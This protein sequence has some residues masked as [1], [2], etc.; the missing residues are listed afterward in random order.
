MNAW[1]LCLHTF[2]PSAWVGDVLQDSSASG[3][4]IQLHT[5]QSKVAVLRLTTDCET[6]MCVYLFHRA[7]GFSFLTFLRCHSS[8]HPCSINEKSFASLQHQSIHVIDTRCG[9][10]VLVAWWNSLQSDLLEY[11]FVSDTSLVA[12]NRWMTLTPCSVTCWGRWTSSLRWAKAVVMTTKVWMVIRFYSSSSLHILRRFLCYL[13]YY[14]SLIITY[15]YL[16]FCK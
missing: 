7:G 2:L 4:A 15:Y 3:H 10:T 6:C 8:W 1:K 13:F 12:L 14:L 11:L 16:L 5:L 9:T